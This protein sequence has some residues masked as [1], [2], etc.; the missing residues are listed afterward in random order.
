M[1][2]I[3]VFSTNFLIGATEKLQ[4][5]EAFLLNRY[6]GESIIFD[7]DKVLAEFEGG[8]AYIAPY[9]DEHQGSIPVA[10]GGYAVHEYEPPLVAPSR[11]TTL[12][13][14]KTR[15]IGEALVG[16][17]TKEERSKRLQIRDIADLNNRVTRRE[18]VM[19]GEILTSNQLVVKEMI[20][21]SEEGQTSTMYF[22]DPTGSNPAA[23][24]SSLWTT[25]AIAYAEIAAM[26]EG[27]AESG[28]N[29]TDLLLGS[30]AWGTLFGFS[31]FRALL[32]NRRIYA[33]EVAE[34][35]VA[36]G[37]RSAGFINV[38]GFELE[39]FVID[40]SYKE[41]DGTT[42]KVFGS[43][44]ACVTAPGIG[45]AL[46]AAITF[47]PAMETD[48]VTV[49]QKRVAYVQVEK[50]SRELVLASRPLL[51]PKTIAPF[52]FATVLS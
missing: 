13:T 2:E 49:E 33:G 16:G 37:V 23:F 32:D 42:K 35:R 34:K 36:Q 18:E 26:C 44:N 10:R 19:A 50:Q 4:P 43:K 14:L 9:V 27:V 20:S 46:Y 38:A 28:V 12:D 25:F 11:I 51:V 45:R 47:L 1:P 6:F 41:N 17:E 52:R 24:S 21:A 7:S 48:F 39:I 40:E 15:G 30:D 8:N 5:A 29:P 22:Y 3:N 31:E